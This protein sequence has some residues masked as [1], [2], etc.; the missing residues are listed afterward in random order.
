[1]YKALHQRTITIEIIAGEKQCSLWYQHGK[2]KFSHSV[3][4]WRSCSF[5]T[6]AVIMGVQ[7]GEMSKLGWLIRCSSRGMGW[8]LYFLYVE[9]G[10]IYKTFSSFQHILWPSLYACWANF[11]FSSK[12]CVRLYLCSW[13]C[14]SKSLLVSPVG[15]S[16]SQTDN[17]TPS[18]GHSHIDG[19][20]PSI[21]VKQTSKLLRSN[22]H[23]VANAGSIY[24][25][26]LAAWLPVHPHR[27]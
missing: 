9:V 16:H 10:S 25:L 2:N 7:M 12:P 15:T 5:F 17:Q 4:T 26:Q 22:T 23:R 19:Q 14:T 13:I 21:T 8:F 18:F 27:R 20:T 24:T 3:Y 1:M 11:D 6:S